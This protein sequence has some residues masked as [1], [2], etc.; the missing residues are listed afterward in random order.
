MITAV[1]GLYA[2]EAL[3]VSSAIQNNPSYSS[4]LS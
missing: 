2:A 4:G 1:V 3:G